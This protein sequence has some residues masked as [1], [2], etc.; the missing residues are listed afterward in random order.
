MKRT[1]TARAP[2]VLL[3]VV[4]LAGCSDVIQ[5]ASPFSEQQA[6]CDLRPGKAQCTDIRKFR[7]P[8][9]VTF[10]GVCESLKAA[11][12]DTTGYEDDATCTT[13]EMWGGCQTENGD[14][15]LQTNW[16][17]KGDDYKTEEDAKKECDGTNWVGPQ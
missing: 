1:F 9:L 8:S 4:S 12:T 14:G 13:E 10:Q 6:R 3:G 2:F 7:G 16:F 15:S 17:Y 5:S 11:T